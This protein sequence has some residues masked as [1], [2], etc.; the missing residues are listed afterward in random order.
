MISKL[1]QLI[2]FGLLPYL[3]VTVSAPDRPYRDDVASVEGQ[4]IETDPS[5][6]QDDVEDAK[7]QA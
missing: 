5:L 4:Q 7:D 6:E 1:A 3:A 2:L